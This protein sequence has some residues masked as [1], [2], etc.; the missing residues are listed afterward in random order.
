M[1]LREF[2]FFLGL[3]SQVGRNLFFL[4]LFFLFSL[5]NDQHGIFVADN[6]LFVDF[7]LFNF[8]SFD[9]FLFFFFEFFHFLEENLGFSFL[10]FSGFKSFDLSGLDLVNDDF[11]TFEGFD[12]FV[13]LDFLLFLDFFES[14]KFHNFVFFL[15]LNFVVFPLSFFFIKLSF[16]DGGGLSIG[17]HLVHLL[18]IIEFLLRDFN[19]F[20][21]DVFFL[22]GLFPFDIVQRNVF[23]FFLFQLEHLLSLGFSKCKLILLFLLSK[24]FFE[25]LLLFGGLSNH[26]L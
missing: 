18:D 19:C 11:L 1:F 6:N 16:S 9:F 21:I 15:L 4:L 25:L 12:F 23:L 7:G 22:F 14:L 17:D 3:L 20:L 2:G 24:F 26:V 8:F 10:F 5:L 13:F